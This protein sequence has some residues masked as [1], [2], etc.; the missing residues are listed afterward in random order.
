LRHVN[1]TYHHQNKKNLF[2]NLSRLLDTSNSQVQGICR[3]NHF[4]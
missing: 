4:I 2:Q 1:Q 3:M